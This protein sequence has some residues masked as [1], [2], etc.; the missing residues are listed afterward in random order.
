MRFIKPSPCMIVCVLAWVSECEA[1]TYR[2]PGMCVMCIVCMSY[3]VCV[4]LC[5]S[6]ALPIVIP[7]ARPVYPIT[8]LELSLRVRGDE[9]WVLTHLL[10]SYIRC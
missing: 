2:M 9:V 5:F 4:C 10:C 3:G 1:F 8:M 6:R 7:V